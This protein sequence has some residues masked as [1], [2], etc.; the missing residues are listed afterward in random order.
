[1][2]DRS[3]NW[4]KFKWHTLL[5]GLLKI[6]FRMNLIYLLRLLINI[7]SKKQASSIVSKFSLLIPDGYKKTPQNSTGPIS[8]RGGSVTGIYHGYAY[9]GYKPT[10]DSERSKAFSYLLG[11]THRKDIV[12]SWSWWNFGGRNILSELE[13]SVR[14]KTSRSDGDDNSSYDSKKG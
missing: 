12:I 7:A 1:M 3:P 13:R 4:I 11:H 5:A 14:W 10:S 2:W 8:G 6:F 9:Q